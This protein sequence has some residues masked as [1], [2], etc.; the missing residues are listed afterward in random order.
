MGNKSTRTR[1][2]KLNWFSSIGLQIITAISGIILPRIIIPTFGSNINGTI[3]SI[4][5]F[6]S[7]M[8][9]LEAGVG[10]VFRASL[11]KPLYKKDYQQ[12][13]GIINAQ[14]K[15]YR[16]LGCVFIAYIAILCF[17]Y[18]L[19]VKTDLDREY[20]IILIIALST[21]TFLEYFVSLPYQSLIIAD[22]MVRLVN[23]LGSIVVLCNMAITIIL[24]KIGA[25][26]IAIKISTAAIAILKPIT[27]IVYIKR[28]YKLD[29]SAI[30]DSST[31]GQRKNGMVHH[32]AFY[33][34]RNTDIILLSIFVGATTVSVY[35]IYLAIVTGIESF[36]TS[37]SGSLGAGVGNVLASKDQKA[38]DRTVDQ[39]EL[40]QGMMTSILFSITSLMLLPFIRIYTAEMA[41][42]NYTQP[43]FGFILIAAEAVYCLRCIYSTIIMNGNK[44]K[45]TQAGAILESILN[46]AV[47][48]ALIIFL[49]T[50]SSKLIGIA[51]GTFSG[52]TARLVFE[53]IYLKK[54]LIFRPVHRALK[55]ILV[56][57]A[58]SALSII[59][60]SL[61]INYS[62]STIVEWVAKG[63]VTAVIVAFET[64]GICY[65]FIN[66]I[67]KDLFH[68]LIMNKK[69]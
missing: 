25:S 28:N 63:I 30:P 13:S 19:A 69:G 45:E 3:V 35:S 40:I 4:T 51:I 55:T 65:I 17:V 6:I 61:L 5:Q 46:L 24:V 20:V 22:Q 11:Y 42:A 64:L 32:F 12:V 27:Y 14:K 57:V 52:M 9:L 26:I 23:I 47:S 67:T 62:C 39:F 33:I 2:A 56:C 8:T 50:E 66:G 16:K 43:V 36:I 10:S 68:R 53:I 7:Y 54:G 49:P 37:I 48:L 1:N 44:F 29:K 34:H 21:G 60:C 58:A 31:L 59:T 15:Y 38:I 18:P 41:D